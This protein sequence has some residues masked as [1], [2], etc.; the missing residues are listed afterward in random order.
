MNFIYSAW[1]IRRFKE[2]MYVRSHEIW[3]LG[4]SLLTLARYSLIMFP[5]ENGNAKGTRTLRM[6]S[7][8]YKKSLI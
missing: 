1:K 5:D 4:I 2:E 8:G 7:P 3:V 6:F